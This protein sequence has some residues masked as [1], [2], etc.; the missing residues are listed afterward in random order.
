MCHGQA[1]YG[2]DP[3]ERAVTPIID[4]DV[5]QAER[6]CDGYGWFDGG[7]TY[8]QGADGAVLKDGES[9]LPPGTAPDRMGTQVRFGQLLIERDDYTSLALFDL[10]RGVVEATTTDTSKT[11][12]S[13]AN[14]GNGCVAWLQ[15]D[16][17]G[18]HRL[19]VWNGGEIVPWGPVPWSAIET[20][21]DCDD[22]V[23]GRGGSPFDPTFYRTTPSSTDVVAS[24]Y[25][26]FDGACGAVV[27]VDARVI[28][29]TCGSAAERIVPL[30]PFD[31]DPQ[32]TYLARFRADRRRWSLLLHASDVMFAAV[33]SPRRRARA[34]WVEIDADYGVEVP[35]SVLNLRGETCVGWVSN[36]GAVATGLWRSCAST[37]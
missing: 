2:A 27:D 33:R 7:V 22:A 21:A 25:M 29:V 23:I 8:C 17:G 31:W 18:G 6:L 1:G 28:R 19:V 35:N 32:D 34:D 12:S 36:D 11:L 16:G 15:A 24:G 5:E 26:R 37:K 20:I 14:L 30:P 3:S 4:L 13:L 10:H 9:I